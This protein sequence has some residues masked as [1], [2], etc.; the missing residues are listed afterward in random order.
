MSNYPTSNAVHGGQIRSASIANEL[1]RHGH[2]V[3]TIAV[4]VPDHYSPDSP[5][6]VSFDR[7]SIYWSDE[8]LY[9]SDYLGGLHARHS[10]DAF[11]L[12]NDKVVRFEPDAIVVEQPWLMPAAKLLKDMHG[13]SLVYSS[14][15]VEY[16]LKEDVL[17]RASVDAAESE[18]LIRDIRALE[19]AAVA[20]SDLVIACTPA[21]A[22]TY[23][24]LGFATPIV[25][26]G[27][28]VGP[29]SCSSARV[30]QWKGYMGQPYPIFVS[31]A[32]LPNAHG[33]WDMMSPGL[34]FLGPEEH[35]VIAG[36]V[37]DIILR[38]AAEN[39]LQRFNRSRIKLLGRMEKVELQAAVRASRVVLLPITSGEGSNLKTAEALE[40]GCEIVGTSKAFRGFEGA[41]ALDN[42][43]IADTSGD[44]RRKVRNILDAPWND[45]GTPLSIRS[46]FY[47][48]TLLKDA[49]EAI[50]NL[51]CSGATH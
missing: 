15:N 23:R 5:D 41:M 36:S 16:R 19:Y 1:R 28:G 29:F 46:Q 48:P 20:D 30:A 6:D 43:H 32:H 21:D 50:S 17:R 14:Q 33:F 18:A 9:L 25:V 31:S 12:L 11:Q 39:P 4:Y 42:V 49:V 47:W 24:Q 2:D 22:A 7:D 44:F 13:I 51:S 26:G 40:S 10:K 38:M 8:L 35:I 27:N 3:A 37:C 34:T 45:E